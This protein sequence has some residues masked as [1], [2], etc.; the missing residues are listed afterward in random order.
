MLVSPAVLGVSSA[1]EAAGTATM[2]GA[3]A[4]AAPLMAMVLPPGSDAASVALAAAASARGAA[5][6]GI[7]GELTA[8]RGLYG[9]AIAANG[10]AYTATDA[11]SQ[12]A[13]VI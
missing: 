7:L 3:T 8:T 11:I 1:L 13:L 9:A 2:G 5:G 10:V 4:G 12:A 6:A